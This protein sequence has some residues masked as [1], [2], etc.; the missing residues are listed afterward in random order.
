MSIDL[1]KIKSLATMYLL[2]IIIGVSI[3]S[4][5][6]DSKALR[7]KKLKREAKICKFIGYA[8]LIGGITFFVVLKY[9]L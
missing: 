8:Y 6:I 4:I 1:E 7:K 9:I 3:F 5:F 2:L